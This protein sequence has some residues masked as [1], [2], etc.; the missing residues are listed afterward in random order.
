MN[1][2]QAVQ[3]AWYR[4]RL[5]YKYHGG[6]RKIEDVLRNLPGQLRVVCCSRQFGKTYWGVSRAISLCIKVP[7]ARVKI[8]TAFLTDLAELII[9]AFEEVLKDCPDATRP[10]Y[11]DSKKKYVFPNGSEIKLIG[12]DKNPNGLRGQ[13]PDLILLEEAAFIANL[14]YLY[15]SVLVPATT[16]RPDCEII[17]ISTP[18]NTPAHPFSDFAERAK[19][20]GCYAEFTIFDNPMLGPDTILRLMK[21]SGCKWPCS[22]LEA[23]NTLDLMTA[24]KVR[25]FPED[26][27][28]S[29]TFK[30]E[31]LCQFILDD[32]LALAAEWKDSFVQDVPRDEFYGYYHKLVGQDLGRKD[33]TA[34]IFSY[35][36][37]RKAALVI[38][39]E[40]TMEGTRWT[41]KTLRDEVRKKEWELWSGERTPYRIKGD[42]EK[43][44]QFVKVFQR[45]SDNNNPHLLNDLSSIHD[46]HF[47]AVTKDSSL[48]QMVNRV[49]EWVKTGRIIVHPR[50]KMLIGCLKNGI[51]D[52]NRKEFA[53]SKVYG[54]FDHFAALMYQLIHVPSSSNPIPADHGFVN[55]SAW[56]HNIKG[57]Q[58]PNANALGNLYGPN[59]KIAPVVTPDTMRSIAKNG[60][61]IRR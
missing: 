8:G 48:E 40:L 46:L 61:K 3:E 54:H 26:W 15:Q 55:Q 41:T 5:I 33:H 2:A 18:P 1:R 39:D 45:I 57:N 31:Y 11:K 17:L 14:D 43:E 22:D 12:L 25:E 20:E 32:D 24:A 37:F 4:G 21:E 6:Q 28:I 49:R 23:I 56:L 10:V 42:N 16:H 34:L 44:T 13:V 35:Y 51:W 38:E 36:D 60:T 58:S 47:M 7:N 27:H 50:C 59:R 30:R 52:K 53:R 9:P 19:L 29:N